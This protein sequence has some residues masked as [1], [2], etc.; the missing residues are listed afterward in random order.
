MNSFTQVAEQRKLLE[1]AV[2]QALELAQVNAVSIEVGVSKTTGINVSTRYGIAENI[3]FNND[4]V[5]GITVYKNNCKGSASSNDISY[6]AINRTLQAAIDI[7]CSTSPDIF[8][9]LAEANLLAYEAPEL[10]LYHPWLGE[11]SEAIE[12]A[13]CA[14]QTALKSDKRIINTEGGNFS[15]H[16]NIKAFGNSH[17][18]LQ[19]YCSSNHVISSCVIAKGKVGMERDYAYT[20]SRVID[21]LKSPQWVGTECAQRAISRLEARKLTTM[22]SPVVFSA[23]VA[24]SL[25]GHLTAAISGN[26]VY[27]KSTLLLDSLKKQIMPAWLN[28][29]EKPHIYRGLASVPFDAEGVLTQR[30]SIV[31]NGILQTWILASYAA[32]KL[33]LHSTG[34]AGGISNWFVSGP[35]YSLKDILGQMNTGLL[36]TEL[37]GQGVNIITG[38]YSRGAAGFWVEKG[39]IQYAVNEITIVGNLREMW[40]SIAM[41]GNDIET[42]SNIQCGSV[43]IPE[44][45]IAGN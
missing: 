36:V 9:G 15:S 35:E 17:G 2:K 43:L 6:P 20:I 30:R 31:K 23:E 44:M 33:N 22:K 24:P 40:S 19:S 29:T 16:V 7:A 26:S 25:F 34:H 13:A 4:G 12:L 14:E 27:H 41:I 32:R 3:E 10:D 45:N 42:R 39:E 21:E 5:L 28:I 18:M 37:L 8:S 38:D 11:I 1:E